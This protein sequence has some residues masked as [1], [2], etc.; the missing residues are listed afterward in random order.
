MASATVWPAMLAAYESA[1]GRLV[2][3]L[4][5]A[6]DA[7]EA[8]GGDLRGRQSAALLVV[9]PAA[10]PWQQVLSLRVEDHPEPLRELRRLVGLHD[11]YT[12]AGEGDELAAAGNN[13]QAA[14]RFRAAAR[15]APGNYEL[16][17]WGGLGTA[18]SDLDAGTADVAHA[19]ALHPPCA[20]LLARLP[21]ELAPAAASVRERLGL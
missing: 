17:F 16:L 20:E 1:S 12:L 15:L 11:A 7:A 18:E 13:T 3:R 6:L 19:V 5:A 21:A 2:E 8:Q 10:E 9:A 14:A 4:L